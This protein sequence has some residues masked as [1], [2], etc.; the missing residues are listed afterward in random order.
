VPFGAQ[1]EDFLGGRGMK[2]GRQGEIKGGEGMRSKGGGKERKI[3]GR[4]KLGEGK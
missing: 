3:V 4:G 2:E 1:K